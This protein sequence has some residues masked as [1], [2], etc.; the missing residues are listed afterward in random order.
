MEKK[1]KF[2][3]YIKFFLFSVF[4][5][6]VVTILVGLLMGYQYILVD[7]W[8]AQQEIPYQSFILTYRCQK[9]DLHVNDFATMNLNGYVTHQVIGMKYDGYFE[10]GECYS[11]EMNG[12][13]HHAYYGYQTGSDSGNITALDGGIPSAEVQEEELANMTL[14][15]DL[16]TRCNLITMANSEDGNA[17][18][19]YRNFEDE[20][21]GKVIW[22]N[23]TIGRTMYILK[24]SS[25]RNRVLLLGIASCVIM[26][27]VMSTQS[28][29]YVGFYD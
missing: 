19:E 11:W 26:V 10:P 25:F 12:S 5:A 18:K 17:R 23:Y 28:N 15:D 14:S 29:L 16:S 13:T 8:S 21:V 22:H 4:V 3:D 20:F 1:V 24:D 2:I 6:F 9:T 27:F 7:G